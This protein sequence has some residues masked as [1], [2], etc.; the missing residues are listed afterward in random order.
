[1]KRREFI[2][3]LG[4]AAAWPLGARA[5][6]SGRVRR[7]GVLMAIPA[8]DPEAKSRGAAFVQGLQQLG[9][10]DGQ[11]VRID[12]RWAGVN[13]DDCVE[14]R[15]N[16]SRSPQTSYCPNECICRTVPQATRTFRSYS[17]SSPIRSGAGYVESLAHPGGNATGFTIQHAMRAKWLELLKDIAPGVTRAAVYSDTTIASACGQLGAIQS[18][19][20]SFGVEVRSS[21]V[22]D[23]GEIER[24]ITAFARSANGGLIIARIPGHSQFIAS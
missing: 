23:A 19:A 16:W 11:N 14:T 13:M 20:P 22:R 10:T 15:R 7:I 3:A 12:Y 21:T 24:A 18:V 4:G 6:Q 8:D 17:R 1:M 5:Q 2:A 9:W